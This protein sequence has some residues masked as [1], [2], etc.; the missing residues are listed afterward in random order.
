MVH[1]G[2]F[3]YLAVLALL[4]AAHSSF[5]HSDNA[6]HDSAM[7]TGHHTV[8]STM[9]GPIS[10]ALASPGSSESYFAFPGHGNLIMAHIVLM[11][12]AWFFILP[13]GEDWHPMPCN[14]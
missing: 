2:S 14:R 8:S 3:P 11:T 5:A 9:A 10:T 6:G 13:I 7:D 12:I 1:K 4:Q